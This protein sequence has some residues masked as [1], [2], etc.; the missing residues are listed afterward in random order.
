MELHQRTG[1]VLNTPARLNRA[2]AKYGIEDN[3]QKLGAS[4]SIE[5]ESAYIDVEVMQFF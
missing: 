2:L 5:L 3:N 4:A 1:K